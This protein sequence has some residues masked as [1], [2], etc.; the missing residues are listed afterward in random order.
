M[1]PDCA[2]I[3]IGPG[4]SSA[5]A[6]RKV[7][8]S[9]R[10]GRRNP[11]VFG[12]EKPES[13]GPAGAHD[14]RFQRRPGIAGLAEPAAHHERGPGADRRRIL[15]HRHRML[16]RQHKG[17]EVHGPRHV[18][19]AAMDR[20]SQNSA[21]ARGDRVN[22][23]VERLQRS[24]DLIARL[25]LVRR[26]AD[27]GDGARVEQARERGSRHRPMME[28]VREAVQNA[29]GQA[30]LDTPRTSSAA[31]QD[32]GSTDSLTLSSARRACPELAGRSAVSKGGLTA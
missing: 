14:I 30:S 17:D 11:E 7:Q 5:A 1:P 6:G 18:G 31:T 32:E 27:H 21:A 16:R 9:P 22:R 13:A 20:V 4:R 15:Q 25:F 26:R 8:A 24:Q 19:E 3:P 12:P 28:T 2:T 29:P 23:A 10:E